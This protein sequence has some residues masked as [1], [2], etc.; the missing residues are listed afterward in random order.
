MRKKYQDIEKTKVWGDL[1]RRQ[2]G[3]QTAQQT[4]IRTQDKQIKCDFKKKERRQ[5]CLGN[6]L[7]A[8]EESAVGTWP[9]PRSSWDVRAVVPLSLGPSQTW[10]FHKTGQLSIN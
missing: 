7:G 9:L 6:I 8:G 3:W 4:K 2:Q 1:K 5:K 10:S